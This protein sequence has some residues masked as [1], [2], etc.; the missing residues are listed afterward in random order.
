MVNLTEYRKG[1]LGS[2]EIQLMDGVKKT[3]KGKQMW[4]TKKNIIET[5]IL[6]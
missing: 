1:R 2:E 6:T 4:G 3:T 5:L